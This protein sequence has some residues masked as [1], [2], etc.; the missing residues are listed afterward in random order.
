[1]VLQKLKMSRHTI[2]IVLKDV[3][4]CLIFIVMTTK[5][6]LQKIPNKYKLHEII[7]ANIL[8]MILFHAQNLKKKKKRKNES[9]APAQ[10]F[11]PHEFKRE[12]FKSHLTLLF[13]KVHAPRTKFRRHVIFKSLPRSSTTLL[14]IPK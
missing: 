10:Y 5:T 2:I 4:Q 9:R 11:T 3:T 7:I 12:N 8:I 1:M 6:H 13:H 14:M